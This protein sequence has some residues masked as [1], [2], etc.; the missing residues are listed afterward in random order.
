MENRR[1]KVSF[2]GAPEIKIIDSTRHETHSSTSM[3]LTLD[4]T[5]NTIVPTNTYN[6]ENLNEEPTINTNFFNA[7]FDDESD[8]NNNIGTLSDEILDT[9]QKEIFDNLLE[10]AST[11]EEYDFNSPLVNEGGYKTEEIQHSKVSEYTVEMQSKGRE[12]SIFHFDYKVNESVEKRDDCGPNTKYQMQQAESIEECGKVNDAS[13]TEGNTSQID[14]KNVLLQNRKHKD[15]VNIDVK[16]QNTKYLDNKNMEEK[17]NLFDLTDVKVR[18]TKFLDNKNIEEK[19]N[20]SNSNNEKLHNAPGNNKIT[21]TDNSSMQLTYE[22]IKPF[23]NNNTDIGNTNFIDANN[24]NIMTTQDIE[25][26]VRENMLTLNEVLLKNK[27]NLHDRIAFNE[28]KR[29]SS[30]PTTNLRDEDYFNDI[31]LVKNQAEYYKNFNSYLRSESQKR[32]ERIRELEQK[33]FMQ[34]ISIDFN[35]LKHYAR[36]YS[37]SEWHLMR[38]EKELENIDELSNIDTEL[39]SLLIDDCEIRQKIAVIE[40]ENEQLVK[41]IEEVNLKLSTYTDENI[42]DKIDV[43]KNYFMSQMNIKDLTDLSAEGEFVLKQLTYEELKKEGSHELVNLMESE[44][45]EIK[46]R[47]NYLAS[48][49]REYERAIDD[50]EVK[51]KDC[52]EKHRILNATKEECE[53]AVK[54]YRLMM[55][56]LDI[57]LEK[58]H[59]SEISLKLFDFQIIYKKESEIQ[60]VKNHCD[61]Y[62]FF[63]PRIYR[64][65]IKIF[66][67]IYQLLEIYLLKK[68][69]TNYQIY[70]NEDS[71]EIYVNDSIISFNTDNVVV[72]KNDIII[73]SGTRKWGMIQAFVDKLTKK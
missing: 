54:N 27:I 22:N 72:T 67:I 23:N 26:L 48:K 31:Y 52:E 2:S 30:I 11:V 20:Q 19:T 28:Q 53:E 25:K 33:I 69:I 32:D 71:V 35:K 36:D 49:K 68:E 5:Q 12:S 16:V 60:I 6:T 21:A 29:T 13:C 17:T 43:I 45:S 34:H 39:N 73:F 46:T 9:K 51:L 58:V 62:S 42:Q 3:E 65:G 37:R 41:N 4:L 14:T 24:T 56:M 44:I 70:L 61:F 63:V 59:A 66:D 10:N 7:S 18:N 8:H 15:T 38:Y 40:K 47:N 57:K 1:K 50:V 55:D 64:N